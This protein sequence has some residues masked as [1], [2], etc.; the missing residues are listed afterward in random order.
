MRLLRIVAL[1]ALAFGIVP[2]HAADPY[3]LRIGWVVAG[4]DFATMMFAK[5]SP[6]IRNT[7]PA[8]RQSRPTLR[9]TKPTHWSDQSRSRWICNCGTSARKIAPHR[10]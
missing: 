3:K 1:F 9:G 7:W 8:P 5:P 6:C 4:A 2:A 10:P